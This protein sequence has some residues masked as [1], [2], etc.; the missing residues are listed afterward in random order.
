MTDMVIQ[1]TFKV[2]EGSPISTKPAHLII[3]KEKIGVAKNSHNQCFISIE[4][5]AMANPACVQ[6]R[7]FLSDATEDDIV[8]GYKAMLDSI[9][10]SKIRECY[11][12]WHDIKRIDS[13]VYKAK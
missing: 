9:D 1:S 6:A 2:P 4:L 8:V 13:L 5:P 3:L 7:G 12:P 10:K 11:I